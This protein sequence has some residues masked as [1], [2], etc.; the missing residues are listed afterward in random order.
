MNFGEKLYYNFCGATILLVGIMAWIDL[1]GF[2]ST[3]DY[4]ITCLEL[5]V[6]KEKCDLIFKE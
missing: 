1:T 3:P 4:R 2:R 5:E 6:G